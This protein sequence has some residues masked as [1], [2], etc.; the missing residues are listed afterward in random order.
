MAK[1]ADAR[2]NRT[3]WPI[4]PDDLDPYIAMGKELGIYKAALDPAK[5]IF[6]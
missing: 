4:K 3:R 1:G 2:R 6:K 5:M